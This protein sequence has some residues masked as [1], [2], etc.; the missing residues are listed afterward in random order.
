MY[1][2]YLPRKFTVFDLTKTFKITYNL[3]IVF[4]EAYKNY[5]IDCP[6]PG[7]KDILYRYKQI[8][9][10]FAFATLMLTNIETHSNRHTGCITAGN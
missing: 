4:R 8:S 7:G 10:D 9:L 3:S 2:Y 1:I 6:F 5:F